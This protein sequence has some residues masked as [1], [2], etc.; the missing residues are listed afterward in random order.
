MLFRKT[1]PVPPGSRLI[2]ALG[3]LASL[4]AGYAIATNAQA[5]AG[6]AGAALAV[7]GLR[8]VL[9]VRKPVR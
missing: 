5:A 8:L 4:V 1:I 6:W 2:I 3:L 7:V 9:P